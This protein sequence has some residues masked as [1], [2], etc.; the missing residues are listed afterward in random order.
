MSTPYEIALIGQIQ[1]RLQ[2]EFQQDM[3]KL[4]H[5]HLKKHENTLRKLNP[6]FWEKYDAKADIK[7]LIHTV[8][9]ESLPYYVTE[10]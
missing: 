4:I 7:I 9:R 2:S 8:A 5:D 1:N 10:N 6:F 3:N